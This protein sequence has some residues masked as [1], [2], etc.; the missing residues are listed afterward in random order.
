MLTPTFF[1]SYEQLNV[2]PEPIVLDLFCFLL[3]V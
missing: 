3:G 1:I 2:D